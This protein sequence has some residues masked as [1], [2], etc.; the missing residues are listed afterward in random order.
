MIT[1]APHRVVGVPFDLEA[2]RKNASPFSPFQHLLSWVQQQT[3]LPGLA[4]SALSVS[5]DTFHD[6][7]CL[8]RRWW[9]RR[10]GDESEADS[11]ASPGVSAPLL[12]RFTANGYVLVALPEGQP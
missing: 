11:H 3:G 5:H 8:T 6:L 7:R 9:K 2:F 4:F 1:A 10:G 12:H